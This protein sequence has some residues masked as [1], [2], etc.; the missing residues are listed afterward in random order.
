MSSKDYIYCYQGSALRVAGSTAVIGKKDPYN[1][2]NLPP[3]TIRIRFLYNHVPSMGDSRTLVPDTNN[4]WDI[5]YNNTD[6]SGLLYS[7]RSWVGEVLG[8]NTTGVTA[9]GR[10][11]AVG[12][13]QYNNNI[14]TIPIFDTRSV[15]SMASMF[16]NCSK[17]VSV[18][19]FD[20]SSCTDMTSLF[21]ACPKLESVPLF[22][23]SYCTGMQY[24]FRGC[25]SLKQIPL[26]DTTKVTNTSWQFQGCTNVESGSLALYQQMSSQT[27]PPIYHDGTFTNCGRDTVTGAAELAQIPTSWGGTMA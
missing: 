5:T 8:A 21:D 26:F 4:V 3:F 23:T 25:A 22:N 7:E 16:Y 19:L 9:M 20:T 13:F 6:W 2:L 10:R 27:N 17:L 11:W 14:V 18:P 15:T 24:M 12:L 1:P